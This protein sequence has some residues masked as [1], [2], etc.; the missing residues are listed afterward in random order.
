MLGWM[1]WS[2]NDSEENYIAVASACAFYTVI[3]LSGRSLRNARKKG[4]PDDAGTCSPAT[5]ITTH[6]I[7][8]CHNQQ[9]KNLNKYMMNFKIQWPRGLRCR[10]AAKP[11]LGSWVRIPSGH[12]RLS[13]VQ[14]LRCQVQV[15]ATGRSLVQRSPTDCGVC[16]SAIKWK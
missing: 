3:V 14:C 12:G 6:P 13:L 2:H 9:G 8:R 16:L 15:S 11:L 1:F 5:L 4:H 7:A 10:S